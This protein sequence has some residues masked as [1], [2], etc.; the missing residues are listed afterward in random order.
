MATVY[1]GAGE[2]CSKIG[3]TF[4][5]DIWLINFYRESSVYIWTPF[6]WF[7]RGKYTIHHIKHT[8][9]TT[10]FNIP[11]KAYTTFTVS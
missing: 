4:W 11:I 8:I 6:V 5:K 1:K 10:C 2:I 7:S 9:F 3:Y